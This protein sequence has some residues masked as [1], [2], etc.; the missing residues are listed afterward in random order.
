MPSA[1]L[2]L[3]T[4]LP[5]LYAMTFPRDYRFQTAEAADLPAIVAI[6]NASIPGRRAT[7]DLAPVSLADR[8]A[9]FDAH[10]GTR[11]I[12]VLKN[13]AGD[14]IAWG[15]FSDYYPR[16]A[17]RITAEISI[18]LHPDHQGGGLGGKILAAMLERAPK[19]GIRNIVAVIFGHN[20]ASLAL[21]RRFGFQDWGRLPQVCDL[22]G[23]TADIVLLGKPIACTA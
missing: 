13:Q 20:A 16:A 19:L 2:W 23:Q 7:A 14:I 5:F 1:P 3:Q 10:G 11:P 4:A 15:S 9:W 18:Y 6:Y 17:Y 21:F 8:Q 22:D 12:Y